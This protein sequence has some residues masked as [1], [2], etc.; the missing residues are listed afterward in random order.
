M[1]M[2]RR[3]LADEFKAEAVACWRAAASPAASDQAVEIARL[4]HGNERLR[5]EKEILEK[6]SPLSRSH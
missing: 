1:A 3:S 6:H 5:M 2:T 4:K